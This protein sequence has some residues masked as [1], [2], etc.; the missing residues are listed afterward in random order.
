MAVE[1]GEHEAVHTL[2][3][4]AFH[5]L[6]LLLP[7]VLAQRRLPEHVHRH[8][9]LPVLCRGLLGADVHALPV[10]VGRAF[11]HDGDPERPGRG[12]V[13]GAAART[14][15]ERHQDSDQGKIS[16]LH[17]RYPLSVIRD[18]PSSYMRYPVRAMTDNG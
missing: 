15:E 16:C 1:G 3:D 17:T 14:G 13:P 18:P 10:L 9:G 6:H 2:A 12:T 4:E 7:I 5:D 11:R 8:A